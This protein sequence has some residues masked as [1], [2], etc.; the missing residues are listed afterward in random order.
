MVLTVL[1]V[2]MVGVAIYRCNYCSLRAL[3]LLGRTCILLGPK[4]LMSDVST[5][6]L[7][8]S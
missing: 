6:R 7:L 1:L 4:G 5:Y 8:E 3:V 2:L